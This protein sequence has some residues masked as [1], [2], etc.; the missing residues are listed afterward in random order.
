VYPDHRGPTC[1]WTPAAR[2][3]GPALRDTLRKLSTKRV[4]TI[5]YTHHHID[6]MLGAWALLEAGERPQIVATAGAAR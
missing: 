2:P 3:A 4:H 5:I 1:W 6:H